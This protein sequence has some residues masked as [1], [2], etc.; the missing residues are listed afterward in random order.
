M[1]A[2][3]GHGFLYG[4]AR[5]HASAMLDHARQFGG[6][7]PVAFQPRRDSKEVRVADRV[8]LTHDP[9]AFQELMLYELEAL[10]H[11]RRHLPLHRLDRRAIV[12]PAGAAP[13]MRVRHVHGR[14]QIAVELLNLCQG[15]RIRE[16]REFGR[17][18]TLCDEAQQRRGLGERPALGNQR[19]DTP[20]RVYR[21]VVRAPLRLRTEIEADRLI[22]CTGLFERDVRR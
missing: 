9:R 13:T 6:I 19:R 17:R 22:R 8:L 4:W 11:G 15:E 7:D 3:G 20:F 16:R 14:A 2:F 1:C 18:E 10:S 21:E 5:Q 12:G